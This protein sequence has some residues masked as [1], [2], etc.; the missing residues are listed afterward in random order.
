MSIV[1]ESD[2]LPLRNMPT[3]VL[4]QI[5]KMNRQIKCEI[6]LLSLLG[7]GAVL[8]PP[9]IAYKLIPG[10]PGWLAWVHEAYEK[11]GETFIWVL[12]GLFIVGLLG[13]LRRKISIW[14]VSI[15]TVIFFPAEIVLHTF[16]GGANQHS[17]F[18]IELVFCGFWAIVALLGAAIGRILVRIVD[19]KKME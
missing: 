19:R 8:G 3:T 1:G 9:S 18:P 6:F 14:L 5:P 17:L 12:A 13:G 15:A 11:T 4:L 7:V 10:Q 16:G 2:E